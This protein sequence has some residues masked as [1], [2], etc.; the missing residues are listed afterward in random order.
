MKHSED[1][2]SAND[3]TKLYYQIWKP[4]TAPKAIIQIV[5]GL[6]EY[7]SRYLNVVNALVPAGFGIYGKDHRGHGKSEGTRGFINRFN[8]YLE[9]ENT[10]TKFIQEQESSI[11]IFLLGHS[12]GSMIS[13]FYASKHSDYFAGLILSGTG[14]PATSKVNPLLLMMLSIMTKVWPKGTTKLELADEISRDTK[15]VEAYINDPLVFKKITYRFGAEM[16]NASKSFQETLSTI[17]IPILGQCGGSDTLMLEPSDLFSSITSS[18]K[19]LKIYDG[20]YHE[21]YN[22]L[23]SDR[24]LVLKDLKEWLK[25]HL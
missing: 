24:N 13:T 25:A 14:F 16:L 11:P 9:D 17:K 21:V 7:T 8:D 19:E 15:V 6:A 3:G 18:D 2:I 22:E 12:L 1:F 10:F 23:E 5:H 20:L 4:D